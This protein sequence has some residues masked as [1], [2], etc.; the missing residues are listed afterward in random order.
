M[1]TNFKNILIV[2]GS[3]ILGSLTYSCDD[4]SD[5]YLKYVEGG[6]RIYVGK[7][8]SLFVFGGHNRVQ[9]GGNLPSDPKATEVRISW[10]NSNNSITVPLTGGSVGERF[11]TIIDNLPENIYS[12]Q[13]RSY[14]SDGNSSILSTVTGRVYGEGYVAT[15]FNRPITL[16]RLYSGNRYRITFDNMD[17]S[18]GVIGSEIV[19]TSR[20]DGMEK[21]I[22]VDISESAI[23]FTDWDGTS[24]IKYRTSFIPEKTAIDTFYTPF[25]IIEE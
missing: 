5:D 10:N 21:T 24:T 20:D 11:S 22:F 16:A 12:F 2:L 14:D 15:L 17:R 1:K 25:E 8:D 4:Y 23:L 19:Y 7:M 9:L 3:L 6:E 18:T 13:V